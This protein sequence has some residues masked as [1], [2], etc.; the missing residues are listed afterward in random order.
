MVRKFAAGTNAWNV[1]TGSRPTPV[2]IDATLQVVFRDPRKHR[3]L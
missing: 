2:L 1:A 3:I